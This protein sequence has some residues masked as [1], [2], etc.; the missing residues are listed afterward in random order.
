MQPLVPPESEGS[1]SF[2]GGEEM[3][4]WFRMYAILCAAASEALDLLAQKREA[5]AAD[6]LAQALSEAEEL[7]IDGEP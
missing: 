3:P 6:V 1:L 2:R 4:D 5:Q 7:Y